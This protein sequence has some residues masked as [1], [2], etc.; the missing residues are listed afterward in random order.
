MPMSSNLPCPPLFRHGVPLSRARS[1]GSLL[2]VAGGAAGA[3]SYYLYDE[4]DMQPF[5]T[6]CLGAAAV[7]CLGFWWTGTRL[8]VG[9]LDILKA[10]ARSWPFVQ[11]TG[12]F[13]SGRGRRLCNGCGGRDSG[14][15]G[16]DSRGSCHSPFLKRTAIN[17]TKVFYRSK[18]IP[19]ASV[20]FLVYRLTTSARH[21]PPL[22]VR[23]GSRTRPTAQTQPATF[24]VTA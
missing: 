10:K 21:H 7:C 3:V 24:T 9:R 23:S 16:Y 2:G 1:V 11:S 17:R 13:G 12:W 18:P 5:R 20:C 6:F 14:C 19:P 15:Y 8:D 4:K 22:H